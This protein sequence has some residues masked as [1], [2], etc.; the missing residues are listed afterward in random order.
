MYEWLLIIT[1]F[2]TEG[3]GREPLVLGG[4]VPYTFEQCRK[5]GPV[6][7]DYLAQEFVQVTW[8]CR[9]VLQVY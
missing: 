5:E 7:A 6:F 4:T 2:F 3:Q 1:L 9:P 8:E